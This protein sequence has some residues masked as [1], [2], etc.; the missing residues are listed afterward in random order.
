MRN[1]VIISILAIMTMTMTACTNTGIEENI[2][3][4]E[5]TA[6]PSQTE[7]SVTQTQ[8]QNTPDELP[9][10][11]DVQ[12]SPDLSG[13]TSL[14]VSDGE[15]IN[16]D[17]EGTYVLSG[18][19]KNASVCVD[20]ADEDKVSLVLD[21]LSIS[22]DSKPCIYVK[23]A[24]EVL[25]TISSENDLSVTGTFESD[26][27]TKTDA[28]IFAKDDL[29][30]GGTGSL[31]ISSSDNGI[32]GKDNIKVTGSVIN[33]E[34]EGS[35]IEAKESIT[36]EKGEISIPKCY[37][38]LHAEDD[39]DDTTGYI[40]ILGGS[41]TIEAE[42]DAIHA[43]TVVKIDDGKIALTGGE[44]IE[45]TQISMNGGELTINA[46]DDGINAGRKSSSLPPL[47]EQNGGT[48]TITMAAG[49]TDGVDSNGDI[50]INDGTISI[51]GQST[52]DYD[53]TAQYNGGTII[54]NGKE[55]NTITNQMMGGPG[56]RGNRG[57]MGNPGEMGDPGEMGAP[58]EMDGFER[59]ERPAGEDGQF[60]MRKSDKM[61]N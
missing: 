50:T 54:E 46:S 22:N 6:A 21:G 4:K 13:A 44:G 45:G 52:F 1:R 26:G 3:G 24:D 42:D 40:Y 59:P 30:L 25:V 36:I 7:A 55:T 32:A 10:D 23:N 15:D 51:T 17:K 27:D 28:V 60:K 31:T 9:A 8:P 20:A 47:Y 2:S 19:A 34:C 12:Q 58:R 56:G 5:S 43:T 14:T 35:A 33:I 61:T 57:E 38:G 39:D 53:G 48:V 49:D 16:I 18:S 41:L 29:V 37:D 11:T